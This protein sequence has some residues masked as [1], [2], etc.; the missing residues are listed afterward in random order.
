MAMRF[1]A[2]ALGVIIITGGLFLR[3][4]LGEL[5]DQRD[6]LAEL[7]RQITGI[8]RQMR[9]QRAQVTVLRQLLTDDGNDEH[10]PGQ[11]AVVNGDLPPA[12]SPTGAEPVRRKQHLG[13]YLGGAVAAIATVSTAARGALREYRGQ[14]IGAMTGAAVTATTVTMVTVQPWS[15][16]SS[17]PPF[18]S[19]TAAGSP[20]SSP[21]GLSLPMPPGATS[22]PTSSPPRAGT[23]ATSSP[24]ATA[25]LSTL[26]PSFAPSLVAAG[27]ASP[28]AETSLPSTGGSDDSGT[29][30]GVAPQPSA[31][32][33][34][35]TPSASPSPMASSPSAAAVVDPALG[36]Y[37]CLIC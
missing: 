8:D 20:T 37:L 32:G 24:P 15:S 31:S 21:P 22:P 1:V 18:S 10:P 12:Y 33:S 13:L 28:V 26:L 23:S 19:P 4:L 6:Q 14:F 17:P 30:Q 25:D 27:E 36:A 29:G 7:R 16:Q 5:A 35:S 9:A 11:A 2:G 34:A 3:R